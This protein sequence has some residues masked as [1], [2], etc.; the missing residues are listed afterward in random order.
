M[1][2]RGFPIHFKSPAKES[3]E[4]RRLARSLFL[5]GEVPKGFLFSPNAKSFFHLVNDKQ[6]TYCGVNVRHI[7]R[8]TIYKVVENIQ[9]VLTNGI[10]RQ[11]YVN[12]RI[13]IKCEAAFLGLTGKEADY[14]PYKL[15][16]LFHNDMFISK[17]LRWVLEN[18]QEERFAKLKPHHLPNAIFL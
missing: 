5:N 6:R 14:G 10:F 16:R 18:P 11:R 4:A 1:K 15:F 8:R 2:N 17:E 9:D 12:N 3:R 13:C 7:R